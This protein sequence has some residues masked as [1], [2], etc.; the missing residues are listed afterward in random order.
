MFVVTGIYTDTHMLAL[1]YCGEM[2]YWYVQAVRDGLFDLCPEFD[3]KVIGSHVLKSYI[4]A[5]QGPLKG[6]GWS[7]DRAEELLEVIAS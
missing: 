3:V 2:C 1:M 5:V 7:C 4:Q 6:A